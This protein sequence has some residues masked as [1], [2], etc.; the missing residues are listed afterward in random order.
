MPVKG[1]D[2]EPEAVGVVDLVDAL[3]GN[4]ERDKHCVYTLSKRT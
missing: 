4:I 2:R 3:F 1:D